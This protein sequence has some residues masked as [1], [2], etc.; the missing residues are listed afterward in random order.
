MKQLYLRSLIASLA[1]LVSICANAYHAKIDGIYY[2]FSE[3]N[4]TVTYQEVQNLNSNTYSG[5]IVIP[6][7]VTYGGKTYNVTSI[8]E[9]AFY[10]CRNITSI[11]IPAS[12]TSIGGYAFYVCTNLRRIKFINGLL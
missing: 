8:G 10:G 4:A 12:I 5:D 2:D 9:S 11:S 7:T 6:S 1:I 3:N